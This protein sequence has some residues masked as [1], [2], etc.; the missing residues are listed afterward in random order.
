RHT[1]TVSTVGFSADGSLV[2]T[3]CYGGLL[4]V[5]E[6]STGT[7]KHVLEGPEDVECLT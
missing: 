1:D 2:A 5:W 7:L 3:G 4:K 6:A